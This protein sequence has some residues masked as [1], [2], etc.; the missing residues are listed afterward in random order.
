MRDPLQPDLIWVRDARG[1]VIGAI[2]DAYDIEV[3]KTLKGDE[4]LMFSMSRNDPKVEWVISDRQIEF[5]GN[6]YRI[7][8]NSDGREDSRPG[9]VKQVECPALWLDLAER[10]LSG[11]LSLST[12]TRLGL[13][14]ILIDS[15]WT[16]GVIETENVNPHSYDMTNGT[17]L[18]A[19]RNWALI[20]GYEVEFDTEAKSISYTLLI[21]VERNIGFRYGRNLK[22]VSRSYLPP[23]AT[24]LWPTGAGDIGIGSVNVAPGVL[25]IE[26]YSWYQTQGL[27]LEQARETATKD[28]AWQ[29]T[30]YIQALDLYD[31]AIVKLAELSQPLV[32]YSC[33]VMDLS[34][35]TGLAEDSFDIGDIVRVSDPELGIDIQTRIVR[36]I[37][38]PASPESNQVELSYYRPGLNLDSLTSL[39]TFGSGQTN[40]L[41]ILVD[42]GAGGL[43]GPSE[44]TQCSINMTVAGTSNGVIG[45]HLVGVTI[46]SGTLQVRVMLDSG[47]LGGAVLIYFTNGVSIN[48]AI[49]TWYSGLTEG[50]HTVRLST[51]IISGAGTILVSPFESR[52]SGIV[53]GL[54]GGG[55]GGSPE[56]TG[57]E[58][59]TIPEMA[60]TDTVLREFYTDTTSGPSETT[61]LTVETPT[62]GTPIV[63]IV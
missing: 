17:V 55:G 10:L 62:E 21:G 48:C 47:Q 29:D 32:S 58:T 2:H 59:L 13:E 12:T 50:D 18:E 1:V 40:E 33:T 31:A 11:K 25:Y 26:D 53:S 37:T 43:I 6:R 36:K 57:D 30:R 15:G 61:T 34:E 7:G 45:A 63:L 27:T 44:T 5:D 41:S 19:V 38:R 20:C 14:A 24:R 46:G 22:S 51:Q 9:L 3:R 4:R 28:L 56:L 42:E 60:I 8:P 49:P 35:I 54:V 16:I 23:R 52:I 39:S